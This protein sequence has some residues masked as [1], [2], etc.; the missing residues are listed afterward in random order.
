MSV[1]NGETPDRCPVVP[2]VREW[3]SKQAGIPFVDD[4]EDPDKHIEAQVYC[5]EHFGYDIIWGECYACHSE[6]QAMGSELKYGEGMLPSVIAP[7]VKDYA[8]DMPKL[9]LFDPY[10]NERLSGFLY[11]IRELKKKYDGQVAV[12]GYVQAPFRHASMLRG[13][14]N[15]MRDM[16]K[17]KDNLRQLCKLALYSQIVYATAV[18]SAG[19]DIIFLSDPTSSGDA[20]SKKSWEEW[21]LPYT[22][23]LVDV[24]KRQGVKTILHICGNTLDRLESLAATGVDCLSL[25]MAVDFAKAREILG[26]KFPLMGNVDTTMLALGKAE[27]VTESAQKVVAGAG[28][29]GGLLLSGGCLLAD[30]CPAE[31]V[32]AM[33]EV[34]Q[35]YTY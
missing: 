18:I 13:S 15:I 2:M 35:Q 12:T 8:E 17:N 6:S 30:L 31:N 20:V 23:E 29:S 33:I 11:S 19:A 22:Q 3:C 16:F 26:P 28:A 9:K 7:A 27:K 5:Q 25:D 10:Q 4:L 21:G 34:G 14:E 24:I 1:L 32:Q